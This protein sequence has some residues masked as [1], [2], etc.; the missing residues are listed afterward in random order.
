MND[1]KVSALGSYTLSGQYYFSNK[2][3]RPFVGAGT[4]VYRIGSVAVSTTSADGDAAVAS[5]TK[6]GFYPSV[7]FDA[8][9]FNMQLEYN[10][11]GSSAAGTVNGEEV[12][13]KNSYFAIKTGFSISGGRK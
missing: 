1:A 12:K 7:G 11:I 6:F 9:H 2:G 5:S 4:G 13:I 3:F 10:L 8:G